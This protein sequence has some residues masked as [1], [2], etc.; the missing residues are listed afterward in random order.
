MNRILLPL[1]IIVLLSFCSKK[2]S[3]VKLPDASS[4]KWGQ[5]PALTAESFTASGWQQKSKQKGQLQLIV[6]VD[7]ETRKAVSTAFHA[8][9]PDDYT[10]TL[11]SQDNK[12]VI[13]S[14]FKRDKNDSNE[15]WLESIKES[16]KLNNQIWKSNKVEQKTATNNKIIESS[17]IYDTADL[18]VVVHKSRI[19]ADQTVKSGNVNLKLADGLNLEIDLRLFHKHENEGLTGSALIKR[20]S[21]SLNK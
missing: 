7:E 20:V 19:V 4:F 21:S 5:T 13:V 17:S 9:L 3:Q 11:F 6:P 15:K 1:I 16:L 12:L 14:I 18:F 10:M 2:S 8:D